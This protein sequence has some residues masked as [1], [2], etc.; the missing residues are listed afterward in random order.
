MTTRK[1]K[2]ADWRKQP[3]EHGGSVYEYQGKLYARIQF[4]D[5]TG[6]RKDKKVA[7]K[8]RS[9]ARRVFRELREKLERHGEQ[10]LSSHAMTFQELADIYE[11]A[12]LV[13]AVIVSGRKVSG[14]KSYKSARSVL[15]ALRNYFGRRAVRGI[16]PS[17]LEAFRA[18][19]LQTPVRCGTGK[20]GEPVYRPRRV[21][22]TNRELEL[23]R[24]M[25]RYAQREGWVVKSPFEASAGLISK[26]AEASRD[27]VLSYEEEARLLA[28][29]VDQ[30]S[31]LK[32]LLVVALGTAMRRRELFLLEWP[33]IDFNANCARLR[34]ETTKS[35]KP[36]TISMSAEV[37]ACLLELKSQAPPDYDG[38][39]FGLTS[40]VKTAFKTACKLAGIEN[41]RL[42]DTRHTATT[43]KVAS[44][45]PIAEIMQ[46]T[47]HD[48]LP[49]FLRYLS[50]TAD[51]LRRS[52]D[53]LD[54]YNQA[55]RQRLVPTS[56]AVN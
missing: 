50:P 27:R 22:G 7:V 32:P 10:A 3:R 39:V 51:S 33:D 44:G 53:A 54:A 20:N 47:G 56:E 11:K 5:E 35:Q 19:R 28:A 13:P 43:R 2:G 17:D 1:K 37:R 30:R 38:L 55:Q 41:F 6:K 25:F 29:C 12:K 21:A 52:A 31:H 36:R 40:T 18:R 9:E 23:L 4:V 8:S 42:H 34:A 16:K 49:T 46:E 48:T 14:L 26:A 24:A 45:Q 15:P